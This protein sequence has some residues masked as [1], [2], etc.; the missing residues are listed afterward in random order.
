M[1]QSALFPELEEELGELGGPA[2]RL[3]AKLEMIPLARFVPSARGWIGRPSKGRLAIASAFI[4]K[5]LFGFGLTR[6]LL[7]A[8]QRDAQLRRICGWRE[9]WQIPSESTFSRAFDEFAQMELAQFVH[10]ALIRETRQDRPIGHIARDSTAVEARQRFPET[11]GRAA[12]KTA[13][14]TPRQ[15]LQPLPRLRER[16]AKGKRGPH[17]RHKRGKPK[18]A[19]PEGTRLHRQRSMSLPEMLNDLPKHRSIGVKTSSKSYPQA[20]ARVQTAFG[21]GRWPDPHRRGADRG[22]ST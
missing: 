22:Q 10:E 8:L 15:R 3:I 12:P 13:S 4:A 14:A 1:L 11:A 16:E 6:Q 17:K 2:T 19:L 7:D 20:L 18:P 21:C 9:A 5:A